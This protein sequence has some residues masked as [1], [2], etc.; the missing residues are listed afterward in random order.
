MVAV[1]GKLRIDL[2][3]KDD[4]VVAFDHLGDG[5][6]MLLPHDAAGGVV[7]VGEH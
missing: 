2:I 6:Q 7:G 4:Q 1:V 5:F 3:G